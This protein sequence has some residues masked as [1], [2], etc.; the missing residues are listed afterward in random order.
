MVE[1]LAGGAIFKMSQGG[2]V[3]NLYQFRATD[4]QFP[5]QLLQA[6][7]GRFYGTLQIGGVGVG[8]VFSFSTGLAP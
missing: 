5:G 4:G 6:T 8:S 1:N 7:D 2:G 3:T